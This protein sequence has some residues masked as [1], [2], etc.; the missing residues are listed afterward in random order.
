MHIGGRDQYACSTSRKVIWLQTLH[1][2]R[3]YFS[4]LFRLKVILG[5]ECEI[6]DS[7]AHLLSMVIAKLTHY[8]VSDWFERCLRTRLN[9]PQ[10]IQA[11]E[12]GSAGL[13]PP[14]PR[15]LLDTCHF[16]A[17][18]PIRASRY[19]I[20]SR[21]HPL[22]PRSKNNARLKQVIYVRL[23]IKLRRVHCVELIYAGCEIVS[24]SRRQLGKQLNN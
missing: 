14:V 8:C 16:G 19:C 3:K 22:K 11:I 21:S 2:C 20:F 23:S 1:S 24:D 12:I 17:I 6:K 10:V 9:R 15:A 4:D 13:P 7:A 18:C 5:G